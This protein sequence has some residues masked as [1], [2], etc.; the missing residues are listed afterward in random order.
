MRRRS[1][2]GAG[3]NLIHGGRES[4]LG[5]RRVRARGPQNRGFGACNLENCRPGPP[6]RRP[7][8]YD[9]LY[10]VAM[11][12]FSLLGIAVSAATARPWPAE[13]LTLDAALTMALAYSP[14]I[15]K[16]QEDLRE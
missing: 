10:K 8:I 16:S 4:D 9:F 14:A 3:L 12:L 2:Q 7:L 6:T 15:L 1:I 13:P 11:G 5:R